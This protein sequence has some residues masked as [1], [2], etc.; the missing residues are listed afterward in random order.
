MRTAILTLVL[1]LASALPLQA[2]LSNVCVF[3][4]HGG[5]ATADTPA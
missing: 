2:E 1:F 3:V 5:S 4:A